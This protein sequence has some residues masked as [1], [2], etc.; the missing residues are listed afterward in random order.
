[1]PKVEALSKR[2]LAGRA[3]AARRWSVYVIECNNGAFYAGI[4]TDVAARYAAHVAGN[5][6]RYTRANPPRALLGELVYPDKSAASKA[7]AA[8]KRMRSVEKL[9]LLRVLT[10]PQRDRRA[11]AKRIIAA[12]ITGGL[13]ADYRRRVT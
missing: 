8:I 3:S 10:G 2:V 12:R 9:E 4:T 6:A 1:V 13:P 11:R 5:G 7:E